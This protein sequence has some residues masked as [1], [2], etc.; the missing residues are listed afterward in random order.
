MFEF[1][2]SQNEG[3]PLST[4]I[5]R[6]AIISVLAHLT[7]VVALVENP[8]WLQ[9]GQVHDFRGASMFWRLFQKPKDEMED[10]RIV[11]FAD[12]KP[13]QMPSEATLKK[14]MYDW[15]KKGEN[16]PAVKIRLK[17]DLE[18]AKKKT[19][20]M[21][22][23][24]ESKTPDIKLPSNEMTSTG[25]E[26]TPGTQESESKQPGGPAGSQISAQG[27][28]TKKITVPLPPPSPAKTE[29]ANNTAPSSIPNSI[30]T[31]PQS[32]SESVKYFD[33][34]KQ[35]I[36]KEGSGF[37]GVPKGF[38]LGA[39]ADAIMETIKENWYIPSNLRNS[40]GHTTVI[41]YIDKNGRFSGTR[42]V[43][44]SGNNS[45]DYAALNAIIKS[46]PAKPLPSDFPGDRVGAKFV[47]SYNEP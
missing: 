5:I 39:Y 37:F 11:A 28:G 34:E 8:E 1:A 31:T 40:Q 27:D 10:S 20:P 26:S 42:I 32:D 46:D 43:Q 17:D 44:G 24:E 6:S 9:L 3:K 15:D 38:P 30:K 12:I 35:A 19:P 25:K 14:L 36:A 29:I 2:I 18:I 7:M 22:K 41:F 45:L 33:N 23:V 47:F 13:M 16:P 4:R 21:P